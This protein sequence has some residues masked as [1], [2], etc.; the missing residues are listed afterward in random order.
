LEEEV[1]GKA[2]DARLMRRLLSYMKP[3]KS[4]IAISILLLLVD[5]IFQVTGPLLTKLAIDKYLVPSK[6]VQV[7][8]SLT[9]WLSS[10]PWTGLTQLAG[11]Y[12]G[13]IVLGFAFDFGQTYLMQLTGQWAMF[14]LRKQ[15]MSHLQRLDLSYFDK[16]P[17]GRI[18][19][20]VTTDVDV[21]NDL[22]ASGLVTIVGDVLML[23]FVLVAM[24]RMSPGMTGLMLAVMP[25][26]ILVTA[27]FRRSASQ[28]YRKIRVAVARINAYLQEHI[29]GIAVLQLFN[30]EEKSRKEFDNVNRDHML[31]FKDSIIAYGWFYPV[32]E[33]LGM[34]ALALLLAYGGFRIRSGAL[35]LGVLVA[36]FQYGLR[37]FRPI[38]DLSEKY[39]ILQGAMAAS[40]RIFKLL[41]TQPGIVDPA[42]PRP[43]PVG[44]LEIEFDHVWFAYKDEDWVLRDVSFRIAAGETV[45]VVGHTGAGKT[46]MSSL[47][48]RFYDVGRG[49]IR[50]GGIDIREFHLNDLRR[51]FGVV[52]QDP[53]LFTGTLE[54]NIRLGTPEITAQQV[55]NA[56]RQVNLLEFVH[57]LPHQFETAVRER[58]DGFSTGQKQLISFARALA[59]QPRIL[60]LDEATSS[61]DTETELK[62]RDALSRMMS[63]RTSLVIAHRLSTIQRADKILVMHKGQ[64]REMGSH[65]QLLSQRGIY[66]KL[67]QLQ[68]KEQEIERRDELAPQ[69]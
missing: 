19:T 3:Y 38:Q 46:T 7:L 63:N 6:Q 45:A 28:S 37:F 60:I 62:V 55:T 56:S 44:P 9:N 13:V 30:R 50:I 43:A 67:Y 39:N 14:D 58:G 12:L 53:Y 27:Q 68:Y 5:S 64:L 16:N 48:L 21:L 49:A 26:V 54:S 51:L 18:V 69:L 15:L 11:I 20:R 34:L 57:E 40:E 29:A 42:A 31:A 65:Q 32:V 35:T 36:F 4:I 47:L 24:F 25:L 52:L 59:H 23:S 10:D 33:F 8:P 2:Y 17:V 22:F 41:D 66:W 61:V 1:L